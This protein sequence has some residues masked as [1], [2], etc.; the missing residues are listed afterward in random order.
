[1]SEFWIGTYYIACLVVSVVCSFIVMYP[2]IPT[3]TSGTVG[4]TLIALV[5]AGISTDWLDANLPWI[6]VKRGLVL[7]AGLLFIIY[8]AIQRPWL[9]R[10]RRHNRPAHRR[11]EDRISW[12]EH[13]VAEDRGGLPVTGADAYGYQPRGRGNL[14]PDPPN[15]R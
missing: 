11:A 4:F 13:I 9:S 3:G 12:P 1:M 7:W 14:P 5:T 8:W 15:K 2:R 6:G 10:E